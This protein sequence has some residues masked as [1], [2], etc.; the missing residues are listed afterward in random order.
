[1][2]MS[3]GLWVLRP[4]A[5]AIK[6]VASCYTTLSNFVESTSDIGLTVEEQREW[7]AGFLQSQDTVTQ[8]LASTR[9]VGGLCGRGKMQ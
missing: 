1:M 8:A 2:V 9:K 4:Y 3:L 5:P 7:A 6:A